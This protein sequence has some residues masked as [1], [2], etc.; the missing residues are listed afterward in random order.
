MSERGAGG[1]TNPCALAPPY[2]KPNTRTLVWHNAM[3]REQEFGD[4]AAEANRATRQALHNLELSK[5]GIS[6]IQGLESLPTEPT[7]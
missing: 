1:A 5:A 4:T 6:A 2:A 7:A 3:L